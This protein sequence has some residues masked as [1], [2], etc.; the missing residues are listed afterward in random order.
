MNHDNSNTSYHVDEIDGLFLVVER[1]K[2][3]SSGTHWSEEVVGEH[4]CAE[5]AQAHLDHA[6][7]RLI[8]PA[9][10]A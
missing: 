10:A 5:D 9:E 7:G 3:N 8:T 1:T 6:L 4:R 2:L